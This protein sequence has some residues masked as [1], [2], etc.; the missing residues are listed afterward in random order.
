M[1]KRAEQKPALSKPKRMHANVV[2]LGIGQKAD[3]VTREKSEK[4][5]IMPN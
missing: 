1:W 3:C 2:S 4:T 5:E